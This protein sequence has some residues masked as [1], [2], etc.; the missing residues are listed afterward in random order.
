MRRL[1]LFLTILFLVFAFVPIGVSASTPEAIVPE[2]A[3]DSLQGDVTE[4]QAIAIISIEIS[5]QGADDIGILNPTQNRNLVES[6]PVLTQIYEA[7]E[8]DIAG[9]RTFG[10][11]SYH[12]GKIQSVVDFSLDCI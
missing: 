4:T 11:R 1:I 9:N 10:L 12:V 3:L 5:L 2:V 7:T 8:K 6:E